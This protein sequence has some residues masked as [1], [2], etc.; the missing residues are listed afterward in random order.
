MHRPVETLPH[1]G[2]DIEKQ[3]SITVCQIDVLA[4]IATCGDMVQRASEFP[5][6]GSCHAAE[7]SSK[8]R[9]GEDLTPFFALDNKR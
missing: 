3:S 8:K 2:E 1:T 6:K 4:P 5:T 7:S 9:K